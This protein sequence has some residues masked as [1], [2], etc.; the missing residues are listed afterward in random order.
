[1]H[2]KAAERVGP[3]VA[4]FRV[5]RTPRGNHKRSTSNSLRSEAGHRPG[6]HTAPRSQMTLRHRDR[7]P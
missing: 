3:G 6:R 5:T 1:M 2:P 7:T 4:H